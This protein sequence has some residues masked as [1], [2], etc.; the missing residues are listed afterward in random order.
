LGFPV[1]AD[2]WRLKR[3]S[4]GSGLGFLF[5]SLHPGLWLGEFPVG[6]KLQRPIGVNQFVAEIEIKSV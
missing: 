5:F 2:W 4:A 3:S 1:N 6:R